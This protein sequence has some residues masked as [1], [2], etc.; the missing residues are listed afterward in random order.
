MWCWGCLC[1]SHEVLLCFGLFS[2]GV[3][4]LFY[5]SRLLRKFVVFPFVVLCPS[6]AVSLNAQGYDSL[7]RAH[8]LV[9]V[10]TVAP[11]VQVSLKYATTDNFMG[12]NMYGNLR[13]AYLH[14]NLAKALARAQVLLE[15][16]CPGYC[17][18]V[19]DAARPLSM[20]R[21]MYERVAGTPNRIYVAKPH[22]GGRHNYGVAVDLTIVDDRGRVLDMGSSF[23]HFG[24]TSHLGREHELVRS[25]VFAPEVPRNRA[26]MRRILGQVGL[27][28]YAKEWWHYQER[29]SMPEVRRRY[30]LLD[31]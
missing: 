25:G 15:K 23:D 14:P 30:R 10:Q 16:A 31:F 28:P 18:L 19:Y 12:A 24:T 22:R 11:R 1:A 17:F 7:M 9:D 5:M 4:S 8:G 21:R 2:R 20:Q 13:R 27:R 29:M 6:V 26:L 3:L